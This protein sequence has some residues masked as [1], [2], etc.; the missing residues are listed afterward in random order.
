MSSLDKEL[1]YIKLKDLL[2]VI[3]YAVVI[4]LLLGIVIGIVDYYLQSF[5]RFSFS[6][7]MFFMS[8]MFIGTQVRKQ[9]DYP[10]IVYTVITGVFLVLQ[11]VIIYSLPQIY[12]IAMEAGDIAAIFDIGMYFQ[13]FLQMILYTITSFSFNSLLFVLIVAVGTYQGV[14]R[15]Y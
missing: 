15:T 12:P 11:A 3:L 6:M 1:K 9:Y 5:I 4:S 13:L 10:H 8:A 2:F 14:R 7:I